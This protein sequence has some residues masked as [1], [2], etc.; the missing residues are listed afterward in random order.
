M[1]TKIRIV[2][3]DD[4]PVVREGISL[5]LGLQSDLEVVGEAADGLQVIE[6]VNEKKPDLVLIDLRMP[7]LGGA[8]AIQ[9]IRETNKDVKFIILTTFADA[10]SVFEGVRAGARGYLLKETLPDE[11]IRAIRK[12]NKGESLIEPSMITQVLD[13]F[14]KVIQKQEFITELTPRELEVLKL[15]A[16]GTSNKDI[17]AQLFISI[18]T[19]KTHITHIFEKLDVKNR[20]EAVAKAH[21]S[22]MI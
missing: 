5:I 14:S 12:V 4:H 13:R 3:A 20:T 10:E 16:E 6:L 11:I 17:A 1:G 22:K 18:K 21:K 19:V 7:N 2:I 15:L 9:K 8:Q